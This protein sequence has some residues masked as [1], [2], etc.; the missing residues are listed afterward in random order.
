MSEPHFPPDWPSPCPPDDAVPTTG[1]IF[2]RTKRKPPSDKDL[3][4]HHQRGTADGQFSPCGRCALSVLTDESDLE[5]SFRLFGYQGNYVFS[6][7]LLP[8]HGT[9]KLV[10]GAIESHTNVWFYEGV[11]VET[12]FTFVSERGK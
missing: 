8:S 6:A 9:M 5:H 4:T 1:R 10:G 7:E 3:K 2:R 12:L 11:D